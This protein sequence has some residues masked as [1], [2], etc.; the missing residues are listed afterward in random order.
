MRAHQAELP[1]ATLCSVLGLSRSGYYAW[2]ARTPS[3]RAQADA[4]LAEKV[5]AVH[6]ASHGVGV[7][8]H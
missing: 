3:E 4:R 6:A 2:V 8:P 1:V 7:H 5:R